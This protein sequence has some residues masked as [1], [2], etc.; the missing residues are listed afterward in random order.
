MVDQDW[1]S[2]GKANR[3]LNAGIGDTTFKEKFRDCI[4]WRLTPG[5]HY[6]WL[7]AAVEEIANAMPETG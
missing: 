7:R 5:G 1:I 2:T 3:L 6:R 4:P